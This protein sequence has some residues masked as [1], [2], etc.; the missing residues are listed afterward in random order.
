MIAPPL[1]PTAPPLNTLCWVFDIPE[2][3]PEN[4]STTKSETTVFRIFPPASAW[5]IIT[6]LLKLIM[7]GQLQESHGQ[8]NHFY[9]AYCTTRHPPVHEKCLRRIR[10][11]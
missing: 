11:W 7:E 9:M 2:H 1:A 4:K 8:N 6:A 10:R 5:I 3:P